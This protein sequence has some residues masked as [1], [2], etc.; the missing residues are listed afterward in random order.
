MP[1]YDT[2]ITLRPP[3]G[4][5]AGLRPER[6]IALGDRSTDPYGRRVASGR[7]ARKRMLSG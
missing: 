6:V 1:S 3:R 2:A 5:F 4:V 7:Y